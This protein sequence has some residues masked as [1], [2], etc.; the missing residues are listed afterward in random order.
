MYII[1]PGLWSG[2]FGG[3]FTFPSPY[4]C[5]WCA[6]EAEATLQMEMADLR[7]M[8]SA[9]HTVLSSVPGASYFRGGSC[10]PAPFS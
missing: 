9:F 2:F 6:K 10:F 7:S 3:I 1:Y 4:V 5:A 8:R